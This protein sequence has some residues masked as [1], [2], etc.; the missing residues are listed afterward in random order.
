MSGCMPTGLN[1]LQTG[2][3]FSIPLNQPV[4]QGWMI[5]V[6]AC[7]CKTR[8]PTAG[9]LIMCTLYN[10]FRLSES[11]VVSGVVNVEVCTDE[12]IDIIRM[13]TQIGEVL[14]HIFF[15]LGW[16]HSRRWRIVGR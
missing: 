15:F 2:Q 5:P 10:E 11:I 3:K 1:Q 9:Q 4:P 7:G 16:R 12:N 13:Q 8:M 14:K 6:S